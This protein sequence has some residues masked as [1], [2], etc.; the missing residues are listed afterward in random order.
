MFDD[1]T[2]IQQQQPQSIDTIGDDS[3]SELALGSPS[4]P[5]ILKGYLSKWTNY[6]HG[7]Q[8]R[9]VVLQ[10]KILSYC[11]HICSLCFFIYSLTYRISCIQMRSQKHFLRYAQFSIF[12]VKFLFHGFSSIF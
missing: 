1:S 2:I 5:I 10:D 9:Y 3:D 7:W 11:K 12:S 8:P 6:I 4:N